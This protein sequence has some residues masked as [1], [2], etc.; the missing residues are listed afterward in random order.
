M[1][2]IV[3]NGWKTLDTLKWVRWAEV[4]YLAARILLLSELLVQGATLANTALEKYMKAV[5]CESGASVFHGHDLE[6]LYS[7]VK[8]QAIGKNLNLKNGFL[9]LLGNAYTLR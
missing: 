5:L 6:A 3:H 4:D 7:A 2:F 1:K 9:K 8:G